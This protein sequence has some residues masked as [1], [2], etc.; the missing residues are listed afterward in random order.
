[1]PFRAG[2]SWFWTR[3]KTS[4]A[5][6]LSLIGPGRVAVGAPRYAATATVHRDGA[7]IIR[8]KKAIGAKY[9]WWY[10]ALTLVEPVMDRLPGRRPRAAILVRDVEPLAS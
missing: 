2:P 10:R 1:M 7:T 5:L 8:V 6:V 9:G 3:V 4:C